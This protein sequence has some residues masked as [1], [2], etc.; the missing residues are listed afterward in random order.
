VSAILRHNVSEARIMH[1]VTAHGPQPAASL[2]L[3]E[4]HPP[5][6]SYYGTGRR[7]IESDAWSE[8]HGFLRVVHSNYSRVGLLSKGAVLKQVL[9]RHRRI[10]DIL[11]TSCRP[12]SHGFKF[13]CVRRPLA[14]VSGP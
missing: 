6:Q 4:G 11:T 5:A 13:S 1:D 7:G 14:A 10:P 9:G 2:V 8:W 12:F 3:Y